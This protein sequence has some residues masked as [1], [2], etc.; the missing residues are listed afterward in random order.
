[1]QLMIDTAV[2][3]SVGLRRIA[4]ML[5]FSADQIDGTV[6]AGT[7]AAPA[8]P[9]LP[10][11]IAPSPPAEVMKADAGH[12]SD[13]PDPAKVFGGASNVVP[14]V[15]SVPTPP[16]TIAA[17]PSAPTTS[18]AP[19][20]APVELDG[21]GLPWDARIHSG[22]PTKNANGLWRMRRGVDNPTIE[23]VEM[24]L[25]ANYPAPVK[26]AAPVQL[27]TVTVPAAPVVPAP[28]MAGANAPPAPVTLP[29]VPTPG[30]PVR[31]RSLREYH[32]GTMRS[33]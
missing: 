3:T 7:V 10:A 11:V 23:A 31:P 1:M 13:L 9:A 15:P 6:P 14:L 24:E 17:P 18:P 5:L 4:A 33:A 12:A 20:G 2:E 22:T 21:A 25:R 28:P 8:A 16:A 32:R 30:S 29:G 26:A 27:S 19:A